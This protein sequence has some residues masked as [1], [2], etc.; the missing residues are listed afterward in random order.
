MNVKRLR[1]ICV[2]LYKTINKLNPD[3]M[4]EAFKLPFTNRPVREKLKK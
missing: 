2:E 4:R 3:F 1:A